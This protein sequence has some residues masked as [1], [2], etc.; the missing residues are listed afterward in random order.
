MTRYTRQVYSDL[1]SAICISASDRDAL[2]IETG[3]Q[4]I[5]AGRVMIPPPT[6]R[7]ARFAG[8]FNVIF[9]STVGYFPNRDGLLWFHHHVWPRVISE[10]PAARLL[11]TGQPDKNLRTLLE[12]DRTVELTGFLPDNILQDRTIDS[13]VFVSPIR[14][15]S[16]IKL[17]NITALA[18]GM[19]IVATSKSMLGIPV[20]D[21]THVLLADEPAD[22]A[23]AV[24]TLLRDSELQRRLSENAVQFFHANYS[25]IVA[26][27]DWVNFFQTGRPGSSV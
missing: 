12:H 17:K 5:F 16:G 15:G 23:N 24:L 22:F 20:V 13:S 10:I 21:R 25:A 6:Q 2:R 14:L 9:S 7:K 19:P 1:D 3:C 8:N 27:E 18:Y 4:K 11:V 26:G